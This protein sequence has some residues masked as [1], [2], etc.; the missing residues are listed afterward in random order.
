M[1]WFPC[2]V[3]AGALQAR[4]SVNKAVWGVTDENSFSPPRGDFLPLWQ[5]L[6]LLPWFYYYIVE[7][8]SDTAPALMAFGICL[9]AQQLWVDVESD[10][11]HLSHCGM[12]RVGYSISRLLRTPSSTAIWH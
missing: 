6:A 4:T 7:G 5:S 1:A 3:T 11:H 9:V 12:H 2:S 8:S 10:P